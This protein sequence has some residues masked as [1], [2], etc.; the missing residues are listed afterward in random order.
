MNKAVIYARYSSH[1][2]RE[3]SIEG[4][5]RVCYDYAAREGINV[6]NEYI[7]KAISGTTDDRPSF[8]RMIRDSASRSF[9]TVLVYS[10]D[11]FARDRYDSAT[12]RHELKRNGVRVLSVTQPISAEPEGILLE[13]LLE[14][15]AEYYSANLARGVKRGMRENALKCQSVGGRP[16]LGYAVDPETKRYI[17]DPLGEKIVQEIYEKYDSGETLAS[18]V[19]YCNMQGYLTSRKKTFSRNSL[20]TILRNRRYIGYYIYDDIEVEGG[21]PA[22]IEPKLFDSV[23]R[24]LEMNHRSKSRNKSAV[25]F[26]LTG[27]LYCGH[28]GRPMSGT[29]GTSKN[30]EKHYYYSCHSHSNKCLKQNERKEVIEDAVLSYI[31]DSFLTDENIEMIADKI[32]GIIE[33]EENKAVLDAIKVEQCEVERKIK[34]ILNI[35]ADGKSSASMKDMLFDLEDQKE[36]L[37]AQL[38]K[39]KFE[40]EYLTRDMIIF[41][42]SQFKSGH[43]DTIGYKHNLIDALVNSI[44]IFDKNENQNTEECS[45][46]GSFGLGR[47][48][49]IA[50]NTTESVENPIT[51]ECSDLAAMVERTS[52]YPN[53]YTKAGT[54]YVLD[55][56]FI[57]LAV[58]DL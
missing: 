26:F 30:G 5:L 33:D 57:L 7:D 53:F 35:M 20:T 28:C 15:L 1:A 54:F 41:W 16:V 48:L 11:R 34:N 47:K 19:D 13:A 39:A 44:H 58:V 14:G 4:Q 24:R 36:K 49:V 56:G 22:I 32:M 46:R 40:Q 23:Q 10:I 18:I 38:S 43:E 2:Q 42:F 50:F 52:L 8:Q 12:Y 6:I 27:K 21:M 55:R 9:D 3:E 51:L 29:S 25:D 17:I 37:E 31:T 45:D